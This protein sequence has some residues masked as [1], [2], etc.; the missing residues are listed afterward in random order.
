LSMNCKDLVELVTDY[1]E[2]KLG[3]V[4]TTRFEEHLASCNGCAAYLEQMR[5]TIRI[6]GYLDERSMTQQELDDLLSVFRDWKD[7]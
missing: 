3:S 1:L 7:N 4:E 2:G 5:K 6:A